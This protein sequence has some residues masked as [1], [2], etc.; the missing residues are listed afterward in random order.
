L[1]LRGN[2]RIAGSG[3]SSG[4]QNMS[5]RDIDLAYADDGRTLQHSKLVENA[6]V[7]LAGEGKAPGKR[8]AGKTVELAMSPDGKTVTNLSASENVQ[9]DIPPDGDAPAR[10]RSATLAAVGAQ[11]RFRTRPSA[12][13][14]TTAKS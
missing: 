6:V 9:V 8:I 10:I 11:E 3:D 2:S 13:M 5:A 1:E 12:E 7:Q 14:S 4:P